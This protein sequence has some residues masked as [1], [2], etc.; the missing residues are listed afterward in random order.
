M[1]G[2]GIN[3]YN[4]KK[5]LNKILPPIKNYNPDYEN[6]IFD[7]IHYYNLYDNGMSFL[8]P[9]SYNLFCISA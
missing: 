2:Y 7:G 6:I 5:I 8:S 9:K 1:K 3:S 4:Q